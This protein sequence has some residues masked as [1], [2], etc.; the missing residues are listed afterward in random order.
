[1]L[2]VKVPVNIKVLEINNHKV[3]DQLTP[4]Q[5]FLCKNNNVNT[6]N[7]RELALQNQH[8]QRNHQQKLFAA[9]LHPSN[10]CQESVRTRSPST[11]QVLPTQRQSNSL[12]LSLSLSLAVLIWQSPNRSGRLAV[13]RKNRW[14]LVLLV[15]S[16]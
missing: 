10:R 3:W 12:S 16:D 9:K 8:H 1:M 5:T 15:A 4:I 6:I 13:T 2:A 11:L 7:R 14:K